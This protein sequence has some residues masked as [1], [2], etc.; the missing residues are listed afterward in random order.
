MV[1]P[2]SQPD[3]RS[4][5]DSPRLLLMLNGPVEGSHDDV[6]R[7]LAELVAAG[8]LSAYCVYAF[9]ARL[10]QGLRPHEIAAEILAEAADLLP[11]VVLWSHTDQLSIDRVC[12]ERLRA[13]PSRPAMG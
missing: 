5:S 13:L 1:C 9:P 12:L 4:A 10:A 8:R 7:A 3:D 11:T 2:D 6:H